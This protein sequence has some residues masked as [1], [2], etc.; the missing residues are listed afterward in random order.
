MRQVCDVL[1]PLDFLLD[2]RRIIPYLQLDSVER[3][4][5]DLLQPCDD[6]FDEL[7]C[8]LF[9]KLVLKEEPPLCVAVVDRRLRDVG[10]ERLRYRVAEL[11]AL[12]D[13]HLHYEAEICHN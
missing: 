2:I 5:L 3:G 8:L 6:L 1:L 12:V 10:R 11:A 4:I 9:M 13:H 7:L